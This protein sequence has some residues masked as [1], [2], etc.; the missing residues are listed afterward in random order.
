[1]RLASFG[2]DSSDGNHLSI[3]N[4]EYIT[5]IGAAYA[6]KGHGRVS[7]ASVV[8]NSGSHYLKPLLQDSYLSTKG[9]ELLFDPGIDSQL[10]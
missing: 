2:S 7:Q 4:R 5:A 10:T 6:R 8:A 1:M 3:L 9:P